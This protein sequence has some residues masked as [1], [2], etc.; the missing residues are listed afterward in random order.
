MLQ[1]LHNPETLWLIVGFTGQFFFT[2]RFLVQWIAS[3]RARKSITPK[4]FWYFSI[5]GSFLLL[6]YA[7]YRADP[8]FM[9]GQM[10]GF[11]VYFRNLVLIEK[12]RVQNEGIATADLGEAVHEAA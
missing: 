9:M 2:M 10:F 1:K 8:V 11:I 6:S 12:E 5:V 3:E 7:V 4:S